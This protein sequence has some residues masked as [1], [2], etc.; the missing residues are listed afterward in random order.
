MMKQVMI[1]TDGGCEP[2]PGI[3][4]WAAI[5]R[6]GAIERVLSGGDLDTTNNRME[7]TA[8]I[9]ALRALQEPCKID[10]YTDSE[11]LMKGITQWMPGWKRRNWVRRGGAIKNVDLWR[12]LDSLIEAHQ[13][14]WKWVKGHSGE[15]FNERCDLLASQEIAR[16]KARGVSTLERQ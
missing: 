11:Y 8:A 7:M 3:G 12:T 15:E 14:N 6:F 2:N 10:F 16:V 1:H 4:G 9:E 5:L 13:V